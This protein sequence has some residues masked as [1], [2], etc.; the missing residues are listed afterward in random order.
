MGR[1]RDLLHKPNWRTQMRVRRVVWQT[2][3]RVGLTG[4][5]S[6]PAHRRWVD[7]K[8]I[9]MPLDALPADYEGLRI[10]Q[11]SDLHHSPVVSEGFLRRKLEL[12]SAIEPDILVVTGDLLTGGN[13]YAPKVARLLAAVKPRLA[14]IC[15]FG[16]HD[17]SVL[18][19][20]IPGEALR[21]G[22][23]LEA[24]LK[25]EGLVVL[26]NEIW[27]PTEGGLAIVGLDDLWTGRIDPK[28]AFAGVQEGEAVICLNHDPR[29]AAELVRHPWQW[30]LSGHTHG[31]AIEE[32]SLTR[33]VLGAKPRPYVAGYYAVRDPHGPARNLYVNRGLSYGKR[34]EA[35]CRPEITVFRLTRPSGA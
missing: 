2:L 21:R 18:G 8:R 17:Y 20:Q 29:N 1:L 9:A 3:N 4:L 24:A 10:V 28:A 19:K 6:L 25:G 33:R 31:R 22:N 32:K 5:H 7:I 15:T 34:A 35:D 11:I 26:R 16:N 13:R 14:T 30:M 12:V 27:R 23:A